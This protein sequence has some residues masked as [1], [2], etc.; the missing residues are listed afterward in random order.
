MNPWE[1]ILAHLEKSVNP[2]SYATWLKPAHFSHIE[3][4][5]LY[6]QV[7]N[8]TFR[9]WYHQN[10]AKELQAALQTLPVGIERIELLCRTGANST[11]AAQAVL[12]FDSPVAQL[13][14][15]YTFDTFVVGQSNQ[16]AT[17]AAK[18]VADSPSKA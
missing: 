9:D 15:R 10:V 6:V 14:P 8:E 4:S 11:T 1:Q 5:I 12:D 16:F 2:Q 13:N 18:A 7:P 17:A 3:D